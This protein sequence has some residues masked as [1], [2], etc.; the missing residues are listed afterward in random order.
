MV[1]GQSLSK[2]EIMF[3]VASYGL[4]LTLYHLGLRTDLAKVDANREAKFFPNPNEVD[5]SR[6]LETYI[7]YGL[8]PHAC[9][10]RDA[11]MVALT[12]M[13]KVVGR[14]DNLRRAPGPQGQ[15]KKISRPGGF[16]IYMRS[17]HGSYFPF[18][19]SKWRCCSDVGAQADWKRSD[20]N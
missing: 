14:L 10:G 17:D 15:L 20:E 1:A 5:I 2:L 16:Y 6:D 18:P 8:G 3:S 9:L 19:T 7:H 4:T 13:L 11:S 12:A